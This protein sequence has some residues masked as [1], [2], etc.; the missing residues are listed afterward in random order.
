MDGQHDGTIKKKLNELQNEMDMLKL[1]GIK[2]CVCA[3]CDMPFYS[4]AQRI[5]HTIE[6]HEAIFNRTRSRGSRD[7]SH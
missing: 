4:E 5:Q 3:I 1:L 6:Y 7:E 2:Y